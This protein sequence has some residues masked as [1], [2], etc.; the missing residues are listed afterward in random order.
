MSFAPV[1]PVGGL[2]GWRFLE[3]TL[4]RQ[5][6]AHARSPSALRDEAYFR[7]QIGQ[8]RSAGDLIADRRLLRVA[9]TAFGL[10]DDINSRAFVQRVLD[11]YTADRRSFAARLA[12]KRY[13]ELA[14][15]FGFREAGG[16][17]IGRPG[18]VEAVL[19]R[20]RETRF[21]EAVGAQDESMRLA[22]ALQRDLRRIV[23]Q[24]DSDEA[25]WFTILGTPSVRRV[26]ETAF[27]LPRE[28]AALDL[29]RQASVLKSRTQRLT[30]SSDAA[31]FTDPAR[32]DRLIS[33]FLAG[34]QIAEARQT[35]GPI[36]A[37]GLLQAM[38]P[39]LQPR[40]G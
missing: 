3:R 27:G 22:L 16:P 5:E 12:D 36:V 14:R 11:S 24:S 38:P 4:D 40:R 33:R 20:F 32:I 21:E 17:A 34:A 13:L 31:Q 6:A 39:P 37:L 9:L 18:A 1:I 7:A 30:G 23:G 8:I 10:T 26:F 19:Q 25:R 29:D 2:A 35:S 28:F 15:A